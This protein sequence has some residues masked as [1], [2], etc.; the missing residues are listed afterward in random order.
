[1][2]NVKIFYMYYVT[3]GSILLKDN[4][5]KLYKRFNSGSRWCF[6]TYTDFESLPQ[7]MYITYRHSLPLILK[8]CS[9]CLQWCKAGSFCVM[10][11]RVV[12]APPRK[13]FSI[14]LVECLFAAV[15][16]SLRVVS[17]E[18]LFCELYSECII[19]IVCQSGRLL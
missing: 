12:F 6:S 10:K 19:S 4:E 8:V 17:I 13:M 7:Q 15:T 5:K 3:V 11:D 14:C 16:T 18:S 1:M 2:K 9:F